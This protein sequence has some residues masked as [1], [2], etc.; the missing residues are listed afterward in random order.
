MPPRRW[1][2]ACGE[3]RRDQI[4]RGNAAR[5]NLGNYRSQRSSPRL[6]QRCACPPASLASLRRCPPFDR[7]VVSPHPT[8]SVGWYPPMMAR[9]WRLSTIGPKKSPIFASMWP[10]V[11]RHK[12]IIMRP[13]EDAA[14]LALMRCC[15]GRVFEETLRSRRYNRFAVARLDRPLAVDGASGTNWWADPK[16]ELVVVFLESVSTLH[17]GLQSFRS[18]RRMEASFKNARALRLRFSQSLARRRQR[19]SH[20]MVRSTIQRLGNCTNPLA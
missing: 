9:S 4:G 15:S 11:E 2:A 6:C 19:L 16:E 3:G 7:H 13:A 14:P 12:H 8:L 1:N 10:E 18:M 17:Q 20:A 5:P